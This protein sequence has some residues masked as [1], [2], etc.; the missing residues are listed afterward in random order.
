MFLSSSLMILGICFWASE[1]LELI[2]VV[3]RMGS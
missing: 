3:G 1:H 2:L